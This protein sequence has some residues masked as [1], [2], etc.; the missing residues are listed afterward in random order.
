MY[1]N[2]D[3]DYLF[4][5]MIE[6]TKKYSFET[7]LKLTKDVLTYTNADDIRIREEEEQLKMQ[8]NEIIRTKQ[9]IQA[10]VSDY[11]DL[12]LTVGFTF[13]ILHILV[14]ILS[15]MVFKTVFGLIFLGGAVIIF[16]GIVFLLKEYEAETGERTA[17]LHEDY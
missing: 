1:G 6:F 8:S 5:E 7:L 11:E 12:V 10:L 13:A 14:A 4:D 3:K 2:S 16:F 9:K 17:W 15:A